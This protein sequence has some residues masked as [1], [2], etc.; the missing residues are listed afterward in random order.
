MPAK[1]YLEWRAFD[2][3]EPLNPAGIILEGLAGKKQSGTTPWMEQKAKLLQ[4]IALVKG[5]KS[6][7]RI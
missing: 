5:K 3:I 4:H 7:G 6:N 2:A 1:L